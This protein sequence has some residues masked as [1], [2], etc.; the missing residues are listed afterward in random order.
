MIVYYSDFYSLA[1]GLR[2]LSEMGEGLTYE[3]NE[4]IVKKSSKKG[5]TRKSKAKTVEADVDEDSETDGMDE[6]ENIEVLPTVKTRVIHSRST[7]EKAV[8]KIS[9]LARKESTIDQDET[10]INENVINYRTS[11][12]KKV[13]N[14]MEL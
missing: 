3:S 6:D 10:E 5:I 4:I 7:K 11:K 2:D 8:S 9:L 12:S 13:L 14:D 1:P